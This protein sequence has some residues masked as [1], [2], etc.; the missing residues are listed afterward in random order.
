M[1]TAAHLARSRECREL[2]RDV[3]A[4]SDARLVVGIEQKG[5]AALLES[6]KPDSAAAAVL[7]G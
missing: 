2:G 6:A 5:D 7:V 1:H 3:Y 4:Q